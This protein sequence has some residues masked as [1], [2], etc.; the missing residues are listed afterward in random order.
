[1]Y[2]QVAEEIDAILNNQLMVDASTD[3][4]IRCRFVEGRTSK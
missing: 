3:C 2:G 1:M 4:I